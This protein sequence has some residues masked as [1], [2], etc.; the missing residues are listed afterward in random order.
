MADPTTCAPLTRQSVIDAHEIIKPLIHRTPVVTSTFLNQLASTPRKNANPILRLWFK[1]ENQQ[2]IG[3]FK[4][5]GAFHAIEKLKQEPGWI[6]G[7][8]LSRGVVGFSAG[9]HAQA[10]AL[11]ARESKMP[12]HIVMPD[13]SSAVKIK[14]VEGYGAKLTLSGRF[15]REAVAARIVEETG[16]RLIPPYDHPDV[17]LGQGSVGLEMQTQIPKVDAIIAPT[18][19]GGLLSGTALSCEGTGIK[20]YG[21]EPEFEGADDGRRGFLSGERITHVA[22]NTIADGLVGKLGAYPWEIIYERRLVEMLY[23]VTE[24]EIL[25]AMKIIFERLKLVVEPAAAVPLA[26]ALYNEEFRE[27]VERTA[28]EAG[29]DVGIILSGGNV[30]TERISELFSK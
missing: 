16:A 30:G 8:G 28:G 21:A 18:S 23:A 9:N 25:D 5:R 22:T 26:V 12:A 7:G 1:C 19:G 10:V 27:M 13:T 24:E 2:R 6:E 3:A 15:E 11:A 29:W 14:S 17:I 4:V 20:V